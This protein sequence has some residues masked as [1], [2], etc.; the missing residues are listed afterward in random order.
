MDMSSIEAWEVETA[1]RISPLFYDALLDETRWPVVLKEVADFCEADRG[2]TAQIF[3]YDPLRNFAV[4]HYGFSEDD[5]N[6]YLQFD[7]H[8][9]GDPRVKP[10]LRVPN[11]VVYCRQLISD[12][13]MRSSSI[14]EKVFHPT[15]VEYTLGATC[16][17]E[18]MKY[19]FVVG[20][21]RSAQQP[22][23]TDRQLRRMNLL[24]PHIRRVGEVFVRLMAKDQKFK[25]L[26]QLLQDMN[27]AIVFADS[28][29]EI[30]YRNRAASSLLASDTSVRD[31]GGLLSHADPSV[32][33]ELLRTIKEVAAASIVGGT[34]SIR[35]LTVP[36]Q[37]NALPLQ[38]TICSLL[39]EQE[40][41]AEQLVG[42]GYVA[43][44]IMDPLARYESDEEQLQ[45]VFGLTKAEALVLKGLSD[46]MTI[47]EIAEDSDRAV[48][49]V[50]G[51][52]KNILGKLGVNRQSDL[53]RMVLN[54]K[55]PIDPS[56][57]HAK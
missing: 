7:E 27:M 9:T 23:F 34:K 22:C 33:T 6:C 52:S 20:A 50:R 25:R 39:P 55:A 41:G 17:N 32:K 43:I 44:Y 13:V 38:M 5:I 40:T 46:G 53:V 1:L 37:G 36:R 12:D 19:S 26:E 18:D 35:H 10:S 2:A 14:Y 11:K 45:R 54:V 8:E 57:D 21:F 56:S 48:D 29:G 16:L 3:G 28:T 15:N 47:N 51:H 24:L 42:R 49:T 31:A 4:F 30:A